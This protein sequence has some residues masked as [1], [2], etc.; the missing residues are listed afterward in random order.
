MGV[1]HLRLITHNL[2][3]AQILSK[4]KCSNPSPRTCK[5]F[6]FFFSD[7]THFVIFSGHGQLMSLCK[8]NQVYRF[9]EG[10][11]YLVNIRFCQIELVS[12]LVGKKIV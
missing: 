10:F 6:K 8:R 1:I 9:Y 4:K 12:L 7:E 3:N 5:N 11:G 2:R